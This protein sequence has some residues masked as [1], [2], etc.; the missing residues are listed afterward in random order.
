MKKNTQGA[1]RG[2]REKE[3]RRKR[4]R[5]RRRRRREPD[6]VEGE[7]GF[8]V[9]EAHHVQ[10]SLSRALCAPKHVSAASL[11]G[12]P[13]SLNGTPASIDGRPP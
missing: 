13:A 11:N 8:P 12:T 1:R 3:R 2:G 6:V 7:E 5:R 10:T 9:L 4:R